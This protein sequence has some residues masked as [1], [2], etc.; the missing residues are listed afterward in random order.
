MWRVILLAALITIIPREEPVKPRI[1][2]LFDVSD[3]MKRDGRLIDESLAALRE[4]TEQPT[5]ELEIVVYAFASKYKRYP[6]SGYMK[7]PDK[8]E[9]EYML[10]WLKKVN[11]GLE[12]YVL[13]PLVAA[14][15]EENKSIAIITDGVFAERWDRL[16]D[17]L[18]EP[19]AV[20][21][22]DD[23]YEESIQNMGGG[24]WLITS[25]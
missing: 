15:K 12:T 1:V 9:L 5:D 19:V 24:L 21:T 10:L 7:L 11:V 23:E 18:K 8:E 22:T 4:I 14:Q 25:N 13:P 17:Q 20:F 2:I 6:E 3:S 16:K